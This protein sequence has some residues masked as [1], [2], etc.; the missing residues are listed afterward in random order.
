MCVSPPEPRL[1]MKAPSPLSSPVHA[2]RFSRGR[3]HDFKNPP[4]SGLFFVRVLCQLVITNDDDA[5][6]LVLVSYVK[7]TQVTEE[8]NHLQLSH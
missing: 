2:A 4:Q 5:P 6:H 7:L 1:L 8:P 3:C